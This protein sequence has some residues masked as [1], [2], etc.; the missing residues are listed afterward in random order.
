MARNVRRAVRRQA[1]LKLFWIVQPIF[2]KRNFEDIRKDS[3]RIAL[4]LILGLIK[5]KIEDRLVYQPLSCLGC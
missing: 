1:M 5:L 3:I 2:K 4:V